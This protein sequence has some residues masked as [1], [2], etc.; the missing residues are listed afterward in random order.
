MVGFS[1]LADGMIDLK[2]LSLNFGAELWRS[3]H[4]LDQILLDAAQVA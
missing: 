4:F 3:F 2:Q 1:T